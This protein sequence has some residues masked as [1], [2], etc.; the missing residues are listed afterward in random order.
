MSAPGFWDNRKKGEKLSKELQ[1]KKYIHDKHDSLH[2][3]LADLEAIWMMVEDEPNEGFSHEELSVALRKLKKEVSRYK[4][5]IFL[6]GKYDSHDV[7]F[8]IHAGTGGK[9]AQ[10]FAL[11]LMRMYLRYFEHQNFKVTVL[12]KSEGEEVGLK[13]AVLEVR[14]P[15]AYGLLKGEHGVHRLVRLSPFNVKHTR[16]TSFVLAEA[17]P[18]VDIED[19]EIDEKD[20]KIDTFRASGKGG[21][22]VNTTDSAVRITHKPTKITVQCQNERSQLQNKES[23]MRVLVSRL[24]E[25][26]EKEHAK[27]IKELK[28]KKKEISWGNQIR[29][30]VLHPYTMVKDHRTKEETSQVQ[31][32]LDGDLDRFVQA[33]LLKK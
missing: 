18:L 28:G 22:G 14:G 30:Y 19:V 31:R 25:L 15:M 24:V 6:D 13:S 7:I 23:A 21:Q 12:D 32:V 26:Q 27:T 17:V 16:E 1:H 20:L 2:K 4:S 10:D 3:E 11:M 29:S 5:L 9:D 8:S 33:Y